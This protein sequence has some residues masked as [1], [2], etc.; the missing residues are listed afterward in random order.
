MTSPVD[1]RINRGMVWATM[2]RLPDARRATQL[3]A[4]V[5]DAA[6]LASSRRILIDARL[7]KTPRRAAPLPWPEL[8]ITRLTLPQGT[9]T[10]LL[11]SRQA[12]GGSVASASGSALRSTVALFT[13]QSSAVR[14][15][16]SGRRVSPVRTEAPASLRTAKRILRSFAIDRA[17]A[18]RSQVADELGELY[19]LLL[20]Y[21]A[22]S[23]IDVEAA[24]ERSR[25]RATQPR[26]TR[27]NN[28]RAGRVRH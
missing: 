7:I 3:S 11:C 24:M 5:H 27:A 26:R 20:G 28:R 14:W 18:D 17:G 6:R 4:R 22:Q 8:L 9:R 1:I 10:A 13:T 23:G 2:H 16:R 25:T 12:L 19:R 21:A 15:L